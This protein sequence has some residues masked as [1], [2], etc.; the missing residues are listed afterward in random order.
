MWIC[1]VYSWQLEIG[2]CWQTHTC[3]SHQAC[4]TASL[5][6]ECP[7]GLV[8]SGAFIDIILIPI[9]WHDTADT[10]SGT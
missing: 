2:S 3:A 6:G 4:A 8:L 10:L 5:G 9:E 7:L 1:E